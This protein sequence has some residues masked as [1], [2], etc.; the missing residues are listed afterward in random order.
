MTLHGVCMDIFWNSRYFS[1]LF[2]TTLSST[3][4]IE[5]HVYNSTIKHPS[6]THLFV[7]LQAGFAL[8]LILMVLMAGLCL[9]S[10]YL[11]LKTAEDSSKYSIN[12][13]VFFWNCRIWLPLSE[14]IKLCRVIPVEKTYPHPSPLKSFESLILL[15]SMINI[16]CICC[17]SIL[18]LVQ[19]SFPIVSNSL[20]YITIL[21]TKENK[22]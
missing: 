15:I 5:T 1:K 22:I 7:P 19:I 20:S 14:V 4:E 16:W 10:C 2:V 9:Y 17:G 21:K 13:P 3:K 18:F 6:N 12:C 8:A 11:I